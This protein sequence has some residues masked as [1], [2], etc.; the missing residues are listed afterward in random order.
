MGKLPIAIELQE[1]HC[2]LLSPLL[3]EDGDQPAIKVTR[4]PGPLEALVFRLQCDLTLLSKLKTSFVV[5]LRIVPL[6]SCEQNITTHPV[7]GKM[8]KAAAGRIQ[9]FRDLLHRRQG[10]VGVPS[11]QLQV[12]ELKLNGY[13][14]LEG[15]RLLQPIQQEKRQL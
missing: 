6:L 2:L 4:L 15:N 10:G 8:E 12:R 3:Q 7:K 14:V 11:I 1:L 13:F 9:I 5:I